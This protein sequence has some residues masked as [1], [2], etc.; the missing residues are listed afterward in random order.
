MQCCSNVGATAYSESWGGVIGTIKGNNI[1]NEYWR[2][3]A[4]ILANTG[5][6]VD[7]VNIQE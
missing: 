4:S 5:A 2:D 3:I 7:A 6:N 1:G